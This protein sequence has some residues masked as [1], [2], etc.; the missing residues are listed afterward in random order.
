MH[1]FGQAQR[2]PTAAGT[3]T[4]TWPHATAMA[5]APARKEQKHEPVHQI[6]RPEFADAARPLGV[7]HH[8]GTWT[9]F[10]GWKMPAR[11]RLCSIRFSRSRSRFEQAFIEQ[12]IAQG[13]ESYAE[14]LSYFPEW[15]KFRLDTDDYLTF[16]SRAKAAVKI[17]IIASLNCSTNSGWTSYARRIQDAGADAI[18]LNIYSVPTDPDVS[19]IE[20]EQNYIAILRSVKSMVRIPVAVKLSPFFTSLARMAR[21]FDENGADRLVLFNRFYQPDIDL[22]NLELIPN[23]LLAR[24]WPRGCP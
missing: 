19:S 17:P 23:L 16:I 1:V 13:S 10:A 15:P 22:E 7:A 24:P 8:L 4:N 9:A 18:E 2:T 11:P 5:T 20:I 21:Y 3:C 12:H 6:S 14:A